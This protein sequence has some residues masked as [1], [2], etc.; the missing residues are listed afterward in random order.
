MQALTND[1]GP[2]YLPQKLCNAAA[3]SLVKQI[4]FFQHFQLVCD[5][6][7]GDNV[8]VDHILHLRHLG[9][10]HIDHVIT[11]CIWRHFDFV[12]NWNVPA[13]SFMYFYKK[14]KLISMLMTNV[15][16]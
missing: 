5:L 8:G 14:S 4:E 1:V 7:S 10:S 9:S 15:V 11:A 2:K 12:I 16:H 13:D 6:S 3:L